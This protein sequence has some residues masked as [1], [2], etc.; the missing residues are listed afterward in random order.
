M[1]SGTR[2]TVRAICS[3]CVS[4]SRRSRPRRPK[5]TRSN[6]ASFGIWKRPL[7]IGAS[8]ALGIRASQRCNV[9]AQSRTYIQK[10]RQIFS[11]RTRDPAIAIRD[12]GDLVE[13]HADGTQ[14][15]DRVFHH[16]ELG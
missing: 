8:P 3:T 16:G 13:V 7:A 9:I 2:R 5:L 14:L 6:G 4:E 12:L 15:A 1:T 10:R 11:R